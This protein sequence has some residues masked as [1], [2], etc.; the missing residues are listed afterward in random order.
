MILY[1]IT[2]N[3]EPNIKDEWLSWMSEY[4]YPYIMDTGLFSEYKLFRLIH[5]TENEG[6]TY[7]VQFFSESLS[8]VNTY[9]EKYAPTITET[10]NEVFKHK[11]VAFMTILE[12]V[13]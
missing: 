6:F 7:S 9:L 5:E 2:F 11:H 10:H 3:I 4:Y 8:K 13:D 1:N 12:S